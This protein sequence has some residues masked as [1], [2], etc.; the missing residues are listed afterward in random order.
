M[1]DSSSGPI[2]DSNLTGH[3]K[4]YSEHVSTVIKY[5]AA[6]VELFFYCM[7][8]VL[9]LYWSATHCFIGILVIEL[10]LEMLTGKRGI[11]LSSSF[12]T[13]Y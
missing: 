2:N 4:R 13:F 8:I 6:N 10:A 1:W 3:Y 5:I 12:I 11:N 9:M 7:S